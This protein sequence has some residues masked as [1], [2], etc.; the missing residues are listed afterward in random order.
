MAIIFV[1][2]LSSCPEILTSQNSAQK[3]KHSKVYVFSAD[4]LDVI[5]LDVF[6]IQTCLNLS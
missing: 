2:G 3:R 4:R 6:A 1:I 5:M